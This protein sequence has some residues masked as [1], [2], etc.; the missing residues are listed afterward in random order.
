MR[1]V[2]FIGTVFSGSTILG[3]CLDSHPKIAYAGEVSRLT[4]HPMSVVHNFDNPQCYSCYLQSKKCKVWEPAVVDRFNQLDPKKI[5]PELQKV[6]KKDVIIDGSKMP[7]WFQYLLENDAISRDK[8]AVILTVRNPFAFAES[9]MRRT[10]EP[11]WAAA[12]VWRDVYYDAIRTAAINNIP[13]MVVRYEDFCLNTEQVLRSIC[14]Y[15]GVDYS[16][17]MLKFQDD[18]HHSID[19]N[20][21]VVSGYKEFTGKKDMFAKKIKSLDRPYVRSKDSEVYWGKKFGGWVDDKWKN[22][23]SDGDKR[24]IMNTPMLNDTA[25]LLG[26]NLVEILD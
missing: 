22:L 24:T 25:N 8:T 17:K 21:N 20:W 7:R 16:K 18:D 3:N 14:G 23:L 11:A 19:G 2:Y 13:L 15:I 6:L 1:S 10:G 4:Q 26:Y 9:F 5:I 12:N